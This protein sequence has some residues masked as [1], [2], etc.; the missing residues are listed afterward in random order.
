MQNDVFLTDKIKTG[1]KKG[2]YGRLSR[3]HTALLLYLA[4][5]SSSFFA[6]SLHLFDAFYRVTTT[7][8]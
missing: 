6:L 2:A 8:H 4:A 1:K 3:P 5:I 7:G